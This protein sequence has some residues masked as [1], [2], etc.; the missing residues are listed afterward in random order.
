MGT[1]IKN[2]II[3]KLKVFENEYEGILFNC[4]YSKIFNSFII[5]VDKDYSENKTFINDSLEFIFSIDDYSNSLSVSFISENDRN[6]INY[7]DEFESIYKTVS[8]TSKFKDEIENIE[9]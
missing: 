1:H 4:I 8:K 9:Y 5:L 7:I 3:N 6:N 2:K